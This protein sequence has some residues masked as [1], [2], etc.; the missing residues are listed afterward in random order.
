MD[1]VKEAHRFL[2]RWTASGMDPRSAGACAE[3]VDLLNS[4]NPRLRAEVERLKLECDIK[5]ESAQAAAECG[6]EHA[7]RAE[8]AE[9]K[10]REYH[11]ALNHQVH[12]NHDYSGVCNGCLTA[13]ALLGSPPQ[14]K[15]KP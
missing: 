8:A 3:L 15:E 6:L 4:V 14:P 13:T 12:R 1:T 11:A 10:V 5:E 7:K 2:D 9:A